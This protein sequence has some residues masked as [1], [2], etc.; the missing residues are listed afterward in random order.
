VCASNYENDDIPI[1]VPPSFLKTEFK[2]PMP[3]IWAGAAR[4]LEEAQIVAFVGYSFPS[5][6]TDMRYFLCGSFVNNA[7]LRKII[8]LDTQA[9]RIH[10]RLNAD[11]SGY[12]SHFRELL[13]AI[14]ADWSSYHL[15]I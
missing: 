10:D 12:G 8:I 13:S 7:R 15:L 2:G 9:K 5:T 4:A 11:D 14:Q 6:D 3:K 1:I